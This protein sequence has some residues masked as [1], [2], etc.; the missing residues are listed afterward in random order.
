MALSYQVAPSSLLGDNRLLE[1]LSTDETGKRNLFLRVAFD[2]GF[3]RVAT[4]RYACLSLVPLLVE[5][6]AAFVVTAIMHKDTAVA[7]AAKARFCNTIQ[8]LAFVAV[9]LE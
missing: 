5:L 6:P 7:I 2:K 3:I 1:W 4:I 9:C 8:P